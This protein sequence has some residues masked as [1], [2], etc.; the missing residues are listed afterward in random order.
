MEIVN[1]FYIKSELFTLLYK[2][3]YIYTF[4]RI[5][6]YES[7]LCNWQ[8]KLTVITYIIYME[9]TSVISAFSLFFN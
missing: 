6:N 4:I 9:I 2:I 3:I 1:Y 7:N 5:I 8:L